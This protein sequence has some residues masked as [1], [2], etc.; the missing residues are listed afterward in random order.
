MKIKQA[1][2]LFFAGITA[3]TAHAQTFKC[4]AGF[5]VL[6]D[7]IKA[8]SYD[9]AVPLLPALIKNCPKY[10]ANL[11]VYGEEAI[12]NK[13]QY[14]RADKDKKTLN[15]S[16]LS[17]YDA[18]EKNFPNTGAAVKKA[19][20][21]NDKKLGSDAD[22][23]KLLNAAFTAAPATF[24]DYAPLQLYFNQYLKAYE[25]GTTGITQEQF[26]SKFGDVLAQ[27]AA[28][29]TVVT[30]KRAAI[31]AKLQNETISTEEKQYLST[32][33]ATE[34]TLDAVATNMTKAASK[35][36][37]CEKL[38]QYYGANFEKNKANA[39]WLQGMVSVM[40]LSKCY[41]SDVL[42]N[43]AVALNALK[44]GYDSAN[45]LGYLSQKRNAL[46][47]A[48]KYYD[49][50]AELQQNPELK[51]NLY[52]DIVALYR[53]SNKGEAKK[54][55]QKSA[56]ANPKSGK[57]YLLLASL[58]TS[59]SKECNLSDFEAKAVYFLAIEALKKAEA[60]DEKTKATVATLTEEY[61]KNLPTKKEAKAAKK[62]KGDVVTFGCWINESVTL[63]KLK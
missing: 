39:G 51:A 16:L 28:V 7:K 9:D 29:K 57:P 40:Y 46:P 45:R 43:G 13:L 2:L 23:Y 38:E 5:K 44:P 31:N 54:Y 36:L 41:K 56:A 27:V 15:E 52:N 3:L 20:L 17:L 35:Y 21:L 58:Y 50:A 63:P 14:T 53:I 33:A 49:Q 48:I 34:K 1:L 55:I 37:N 18:Q 24:T 10:N 61:T 32:T 26:I 60:A 47:E 11:Y 6:E 4:E 42:Y 22:V 59:V 25:T 8:K 12:L 19:M 30:E 62:G